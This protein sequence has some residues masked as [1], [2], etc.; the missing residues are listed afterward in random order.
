MASIRRRPRADGSICHAVLYTIDGRQSS[1]P[2]D[3]PKAAE[4]FRQAVEVHGAARALAMHGIDSAPRRLDYISGVTVT[5]WLEHHIA[6]LSGVERRTPAEYRGIVKKDIAPVL[7]TIPLAQLTHEDISRWLEAMRDAGAAGKTIANKH[8]LLSAALNGAVRAGHIASNPA[9][10]AR[11][12]RTERPEMRMF[13]PDEFAAL[14]AEFPDYWRPMLRFL[15]ASGARMGEVTALRPRDV[16][17]PKSTVHIGRAWKRN[18]GGWEIGAPKTRMS[19]RTLNVPKAILDD[20]DYSHEYLFTTPGTG[21]RGAGG[22]VRPINLRRSVWYPALLRAKISEPR[23]RLH[24]LRH[25]CA[26][27]M[28]AD[29][30]PLP[31]IQRHLGHESIQTTVNLYGHIDRRSAQAA[32]DAIGKLLS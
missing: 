15:V 26:S 20:L 16:N 17:R 9:A 29:G 30:I 28:I 18:P 3:S 11:L 19:V 27:W 7:G 22:P 31:V 2:F 24:D 4:A 6:H 32:A 12:P 25:T 14:S 5:E 8:G 21:N 23:P 10:G 1:L 13:T